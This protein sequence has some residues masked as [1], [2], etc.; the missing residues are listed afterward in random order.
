MNY[1]EYIEDYRSHRSARKTARKYNLDY[2]NFKK[3][4]KSNDNV[5]FGSYIKFIENNLDKV[6]KLYEEDK[7][8]LREICDKLE[9]PKTSLR[10]VL[11]ENNILR[12]KSEAQ[13]LALKKGKFNKKAHTKQEKEF[14]EYL[15][16]NNVNYD[17]Q[18][19]VSGFNHRYDFYIKDINLII[20]IDGKYWHRLDEHNDL[21]DADEIHEK[22]L[23][24]TKQAIASGYNILRIRAEDINKYGCNLF[25]RILNRDLEDN[26][27]NLEEDR[28]IKEYREINRQ[29]LEEVDRRAKRRKKYPK[30]YSGSKLSD[31]WKYRDDVRK[32]D[33]DKFLEDR[34]SLNEVK[35]EFNISR[36]CLK[37]MV[38]EFYDISFTEWRAWHLTSPKRRGHD[39]I[40]LQ[41]KLVEEGKIDIDIPTVS[42]LRKYLKDDNINSTN[43]MFDEY[44]NRGR[45]YCIDWIERN[46]DMEWGEFY[47]CYFGEGK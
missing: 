43:R 10:T 29:A 28:D 17:Y 2:D 23:K 8:S 14:R 32:E 39:V 35:K 22:D 4:L 33:L 9:Y 16:K 38:R 27:I 15:K 45:N 31:H 26:Y 34:P 42:G 13:K 18:H 41:V 7:L 6:K 37:R 11:K 47:E 24:Y 36:N 46:F 40:D 12:N 20:E 5:F 21:P 44:F 3:Y 25:D 1:Q 19:V 30:G